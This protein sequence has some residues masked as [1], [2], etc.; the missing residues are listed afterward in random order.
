MAKE[1]FESE[2]LGRI[3]QVV[4][5]RMGGQGFVGRP[6]QARALLDGRHRGHPNGQK[7]RQKKKPARNAALF[8]QQQL[9][10]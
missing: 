10:A 6:G 5:S 7:R 3:S 9:A 1:T 2:T 4:L 8:A